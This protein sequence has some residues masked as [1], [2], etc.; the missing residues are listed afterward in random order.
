MYT[1]SEN[2]ERQR[3]APVAECPLKVPDGA[4]DALVAAIMTH[5]TQFVNKK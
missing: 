1:F 2:P 5:R 3:D 4:F